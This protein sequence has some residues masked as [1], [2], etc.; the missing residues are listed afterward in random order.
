MRKTSRKLGTVVFGILIVLIL[1]SCAS[2]KEWVREDAVAADPAMDKFVILPVYISLPGDELKYSAALFGGVIKTFGDQA[3]SLQPIQ[4]VLDAAG[5]GWMP[6]SMAYGIYHM[7]TAH[8]TFDFA[9]DAGYHG[10]NSEYQQIMEGMGKLIELV[11]EQL[12]LDFEPKYMVVASIYSYGSI[13]GKILKIRTLGAIYNLE[14][15]KIDKVV[16]MDKTT[17]YNE[18]A[19]LAEMATVGD[20]LYAVFFPE[21]EMEEG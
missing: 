18:V 8:G 21:E 7:V 12:K 2:T 20:K 19:L 9:E 1:G 15:S 10:G 17:F 14:E 6:R 11:A 4:P 13:A 3:I 16:V 5:F